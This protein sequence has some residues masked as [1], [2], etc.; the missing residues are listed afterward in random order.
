MGILTRARRR[1]QIN[2]MNPRGIFAGKAYV[3]GDNSLRDGFDEEILRRILL[4]VNEGI[5]LDEARIVETN[6]HY[7]AFRL[8]ANGK[9][10]HAKLSFD[11]DCPPIIREEETLENSNYFVAPELVQSGRI[12]V[13]TEPLRYCLMTWDEAP[14]L[15]DLGRGA[16]T[17]RPISIAFA[18]KNMREFGSFPTTRSMREYISFLFRESDLESYFLDDSL[19]ALDEHT[20][21]QRVKGFFSEVKSSLN[22]LYDARL[23][24]RKT[25]CHGALKLDNIL[26]RGELFKFRNFDHCFIGNQWF[27]LCKIVLELGIRKREERK[28]VSEVATHAGLNPEE[29]ESCMTLSCLIYILELA[30]EYLKEVYVFSSQ[31]QNKI[32]EINAR[33]SQNFSRLRAIQPFEDNREFISKLITEP[34]LGYKA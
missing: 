32:V 28:F 13:G 12:S 7:D 27:D 6:E 1:G 33:F 2:R 19:E 11:P 26:C 4:S 31:R 24:E 18:L 16:M 14:N 25:L 34:I 15:Y 10:Y 30:V 9:F 17:S 3:V 21:L 22:G 23:C 5:Q 8:E 29:Y 20:D